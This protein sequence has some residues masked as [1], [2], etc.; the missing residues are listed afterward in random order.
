MWINKTILKWY[1]NRYSISRTSNMMIFVTL[2][3]NNQLWNSNLVHLMCQTKKYKNWELVVAYNNSKVYYWKKKYNHYK[4]K[5]QH[6]RYKICSKRKRR[7]R[8][9]YIWHMKKKGTYIK[10]SS[11]PWR[12]R[13]TMCKKV[14]HWAHRSSLKEKIGN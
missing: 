6:R 13:K 7:E 4:R 1:K 10:N 8:N 5:T 3:K 12:K 14:S 2:C 9:S 11:T